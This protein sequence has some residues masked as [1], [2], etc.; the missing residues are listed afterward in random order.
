[1]RVDRLSFRQFRNITEIDFTPGPVLNYFVGDNAQGKTSIIEGIFHISTLRSFRTATTLDLI[2]RGHESAQL[3]AHVSSISGK[4][5]QKNLKVRLS[6]GHRQL[7]LNEKQVSPSKFVG[8]VRTVVF[9]PESLGAIKFGP[10]LRRELVDQA[11]YQISSEAPLAFTRFSKALRQRNACLKQ[12]K[13]G[14]IVPNKG[15]GILESL[16]AGFLQAATEITFLRLRFLDTILP[17]AQETLSL[18]MGEK[19]S[20]EFAYE[21]HDEPWKE[22]NLEAIHQRLKDEILDSSRRISEE[23]LGVTLT[24]PH[25]HDLSFLFNGNDSRIFCSQGQQRALI[26]S[27]KI[28]EIVYHGKAFESYPLL[29][30]DDVLSEFDEKKRRFLVDFLRAHNAQTFLTT[31]DH[32]QVLQGCSVFHVEAGRLKT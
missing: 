31:T 10:D 9:S 19:C 16:D 25:R 6:K 15:R 2:Q 1:V 8:Q 13:M 30:L 20:L 3:E 18:I 14:L 32:T 26:L 17:H 21:S 11:V 22:R 5:S 4:T 24:G 23:A 7:T 28:A 29:L 12:I 27:F